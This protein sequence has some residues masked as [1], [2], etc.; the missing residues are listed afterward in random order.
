MAEK[1]KH[2]DFI[3]LDY[4]GKLA[5]GSVFDTTME[6]VAKDAGLPT[7]KVKFGPTVICVGEKQVLPGLD[8][9]LVDKEVGKEYTI[10]L[11]AEKAFGKRDV[12][13]MKIVPISTFKEHDVQP[14]PGLQIDVDGEMGTVTRVAGGRV[15]VNFNHPLAGREVTYEIK[16]NRKITDQKEQLIS[17][18]NS[19]LR[20]PEDKI[21]VEIKEEKAEIQL[22]M[23]LPVQVT[24]E[25][26]KKLAELTKLKEVKF[27]KA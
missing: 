18:L 19:T 26:G 7:E 11:P 22:P 24:E 15:I 2:H 25:I 6:K 13:K 20:I 23:D 5:D 27:S 14:Q 12:K 8:A 9:E 10:T 21:K 4:T 1:V 17:F 3:E 16:I